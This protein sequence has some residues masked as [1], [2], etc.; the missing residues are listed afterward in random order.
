MLRFQGCRKTVVTFNKLCQVLTRQKLQNLNL[1]KKS[2]NKAWLHTSHV[3]F[4]I[5]S[6]LD[7]ESFKAH[8][9]DL[10]GHWLLAG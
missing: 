10:E 2:L 7:C 9:V 6:Y 8:V 5:L 3:S 4:F 1:T